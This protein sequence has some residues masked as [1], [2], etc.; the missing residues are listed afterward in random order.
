[1]SD[2]ASGRTIVISTKA[3]PDVHRP[4]RSKNLSS[5]FFI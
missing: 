2:I 4:N 5:D 1:M 3:L